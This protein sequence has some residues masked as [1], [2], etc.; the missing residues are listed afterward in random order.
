GTQLW[1]TASRAT[2]AHTWEVLLLAW[3]LDV[4]LQSA[5]GQRALRPLLLGA[6][7]AAM[8]VVR[9]TAVIP[10]AVIGAYLLAFHR[11][12]LPR[13]ALAFAIGIGL[14]VGYSYSQFGTPLPLYY[15]QSNLFDAGRPLEGIAG[16][17][18]SPSRGLFVYAP[19]L[20]FVGYWLVRYRH[21]LSHR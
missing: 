10:I 1:S 11:S 15:M 14:F 2:W 17:L 16:T 3:A 21:Q 5:T 20:A 13:F 12:A 4:L 6:L 19:V 18:F 7:A 8:Y 9:P